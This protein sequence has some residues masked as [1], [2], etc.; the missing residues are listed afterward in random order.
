MIVLN[1]VISNNMMIHSRNISLISGSNYSNNG[2]CV[3]QQ[4]IMMLVPHLIHS[5]R[6]LTDR[7]RA[8]FTLRNLGGHEAI[9][10]I[11]KCKLE[12]CAFQII[13]YKRYIPCEIQMKKACTELFDNSCDLNEGAQRFACTC[14]TSLFPLLPSFLP[15]LPPPHILPLSPTFPPSPPKSSGVRQVAIYQRNDFCDYINIVSFFICKC[16]T[17]LG[18]AFPPIL[19]VLMIHQLY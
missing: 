3:W 14:K 10:C 19:Q 15:S 8:L 2:V 17:T 11:S 18:D 4:C 13:Y 1:I 6:S 16:H 12:K 5:F 9:D 7:F